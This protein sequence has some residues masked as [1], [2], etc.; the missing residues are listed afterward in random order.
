LRSTR[1][2]DAALD[3]RLERIRVTAD[4]LKTRSEI[5]REFKAINIDIQGIIWE[6]VSPI[7]L[8][9]GVMVREGDTV[10][11]AVVEEIRTSEIIFNFKGVRCRRKPGR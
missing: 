11:G 9:K 4:R 7:A 8:I 1:I 6:P 2:G 5:E 3:E 10:E